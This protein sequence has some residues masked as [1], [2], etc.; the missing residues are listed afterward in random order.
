[1]DTTGQAAKWAILIGINGYDRSLG[2]LK[3]CV[4]DCRRVAAALP[5]GDAGFTFER[6]LVMSDDAEQGHRPTYTNIIG[7]LASWLSRPG[8]QDTVLVY[9]AGHG[10]ERDGKCYLVPQD[11]QYHTLEQTGIP[12]HYVQEKLRQCR[13][14]QK[15]LVLDTCHSGA[16]RDVNALSAGM[17]AALAAGEGIYTITSCNKNER[18]YEF[19]EVEQGAFSHFFAAALEGECVPDSQ[20]R[21]TADGVYQ[22]VFEKVNDWAAARGLSQQ[23]QRICE[24]QGT[25]TLAQGSVRSLGEAGQAGETSSSGGGARLREAGPP[26]NETAVASVAEL[27]RQAVLLE[28]RGSPQGALSTLLKAAQYDPET[29]APHLKS[30]RRRLARGATVFAAPAPGEVQEPVVEPKDE[31]VPGSRGRGRLWI[32]VCSVLVLL[33]LVAGLGFWPR[34][35]KALLN[36]AGKGSVTPGQAPTS[37]AGRVVSLTVRP[38]GTTVVLAEQGLPVSTQVVVGVNPVVF[39]NLAPG[40]YSVTLSREGYR[41][42]SLEI[43]AFETHFSTE[44]EVQAL[45]RVQ[46]QSDQLLRDCSLWGRSPARAPDYL[47]PGASREFAGTN[48]Y[49]VAMLGVRQEWTDLPG[50]PPGGYI[51]EAR[52]RPGDSLNRAVSLAPGDNQVSLRFGVRE[53]VDWVISPVPE[54]IFQRD[55][56]G[57]EQQ[58]KD[59]IMEGPNTLKVQMLTRNQQLYML[60][61][62][63]A[64]HIPVTSVVQ[65]V[66]QSGSVPGKSAIRSRRLTHTLLPRRSP[67][68]GER[69]TNSIGMVFLPVG[70]FWACETETRRR[71]YRAFADT[72]LVAPG[73]SRMKVITAQ[74]EE[75]SASHTWEQPGYAPE[76]RDKALFPEHPVVGVD[77]ADAMGFCRWLTETERRL[78]DA[79]AEGLAMGL[80]YRLPTNAEWT[81]LAGGSQY[82]WGDE[83]AAMAGNY[84]TVSTRDD[85]W[86]PNWVT[87]PR[88]KYVDSFPRTS[89]VRSFRPNRPGGFYDL[90]GNAAEW[91]LD[92]ASNDALRAPRPSARG[93]SWATWDFTEMETTRRRE[94]GPTERSDRIG[95]RV[96]IAH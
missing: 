69:W 28:Q 45:M 22:W 48:W 49:R 50:L 10:I 86:P 84:A 92:G 85:Q 17:L 20:G 39:N 52:N 3:Y 94:F 41:S 35:A 21:L 89:P 23:P 51:V 65:F 6:V 83:A 90:G 11:A 34:G 72:S 74:G 16:G 15:I 38:A 8:S 63:A 73:T 26:P 36:P 77:W 9:F 47:A 29:V 18:S 82:P 4:R 88:S 56:Y 68:V 1:M 32:G 61:A 46:V 79:G 57:V 27:L 75:D 7:W 78:Y 2:R 62:E 25:I 64:G 80:A 31:T 67:Q 96:I 40:Q 81:L 71:D 33:A 59:T 66:P 37:T 55:F 91:C 13:A 19:D 60:V 70:D 42:R 93:G 95:F 76:T 54:R 44:V 24:G 5:A 53:A 14:R 30:L 12:V 43:G 87:L 58:L